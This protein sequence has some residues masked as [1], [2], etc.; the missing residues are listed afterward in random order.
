MTIEIDPDDIK[1][2]I[3]RVIEDSDNLKNLSGNSADEE[4]NEQDEQDY[5]DTDKDMFGW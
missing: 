5:E 4:Y 2:M 1:E 3:Q